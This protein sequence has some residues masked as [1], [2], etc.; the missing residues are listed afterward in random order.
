MLGLLDRTE[1]ER[2]GTLQ[3]YPTDALDPRN[4]VQL[5]SLLP[6]LTEESV[7]S[8]H[9]AA[10]PRFWERLSGFDI[11]PQVIGIAQVNLRRERRSRGGNCSTICASV[12]PELCL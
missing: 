10:I 3:L 1:A 12:R 11:A 5:R 6:L 8:F 4:G 9:R 7:R 2:V